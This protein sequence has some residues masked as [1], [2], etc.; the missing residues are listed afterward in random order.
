M[1]EFT[2]WENWDASNDPAWVACPLCEER[3]DMPIEPP[4]PRTMDER[5]RFVNII[6]TPFARRLAKQCRYA[7]TMRHG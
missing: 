4:L 5:Q 6:V 7:E 3:V 1:R 2:T